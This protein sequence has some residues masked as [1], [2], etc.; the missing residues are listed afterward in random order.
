MDVKA[1]A[2]RA[3]SSQRAKRRELVELLVR[4]DQLEKTIEGGSFY[5]FRTV[6]QISGGWDALSRVKGRT[7]ETE[8]IIPKYSQL[9]I[10][11]SSFSSRQEEQ[12]WMISQQSQIQERGAGVRELRS[13]SRGSSNSRRRKI[14]WVWWLKSA[15]IS[16]N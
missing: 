4:R 2:E 14:G 5:G 11:L 10:E 9:L 15:D 8:V 7:E 1:L 3:G 6:H 13:R 16:R 12:M